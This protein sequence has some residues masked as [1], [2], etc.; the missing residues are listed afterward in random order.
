[1]LFMC[2][3]AIVKMA[4]SGIRDF[5]DPVEQS[6]LFSSYITRVHNELGKG[7]KICDAIGST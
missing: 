5:G 4:S 2:Q 7:K 6:I 3:N 1:M